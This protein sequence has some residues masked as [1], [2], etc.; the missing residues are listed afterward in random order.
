MKALLI[1][2][3][4]CLISCEG[5]Y[6]SYSYQT[7]PSTTIR[8]YRSYTPSYHYYTP[9]R[10]VYYPVPVTRY[11]YRTPRYHSVRS[12]SYEVKRP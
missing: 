7:V 9:S 4:C 5:G 6:S 3:V 2:L 10:R 8:T 1:L 12:K 11:Q